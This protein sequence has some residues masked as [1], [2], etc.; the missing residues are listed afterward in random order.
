MFFAICSGHHLG[1]GFRYCLRHGVGFQNGFKLNERPIDFFEDH[2]I[3][4]ALVSDHPN[5]LALCHETWGRDSIGYLSFVQSNE[6]YVEI[7]FGFCPW[8]LH[9]HSG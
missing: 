4:E 8:I 5:E 2:A 3:F 6:T 7:S 9:Y 1:G